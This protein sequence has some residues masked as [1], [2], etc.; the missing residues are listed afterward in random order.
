MK[1]IWIRDWQL[2]FPGY[3]K[4][5]INVGN[6]CGFWTLIITCRTGVMMWASLDPRGARA[7]AAWAGSTVCVY[8]A[9]SSKQ[10]KSND[11]KEKNTDRRLH[12]LLR[13]EFFFSNCNH[14]KFVC[15]VHIGSASNFRYVLVLKYG[16]INLMSSVWLYVYVL[17]MYIFSIYGSLEIN[18]K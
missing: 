11:N 12:H 15:S 10:D 4:N 9:L 5:E 7:V 18:Q 16:K 1:Y 6:N 13:T 8:S 14:H 2:T 3:T 17:Y